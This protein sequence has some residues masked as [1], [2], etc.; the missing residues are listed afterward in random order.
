MK[1]SN[2]LLGLM[3][4]R[5]GHGVLLVRGERFGSGGTIVC[6]FG[7]CMIVRMSTNEC[8]VHQSK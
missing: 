7:S 1:E 3:G 5:V 8:V 6:V 4:V 2:G